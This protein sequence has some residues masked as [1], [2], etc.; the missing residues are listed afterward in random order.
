MKKLVLLINLTFCATVIIA[1]S[2]SNVTEANE[3]ETIDNSPVGSYYRKG[4][5]GVESI[6][7]L[8]KD[9]TW[10]KGLYQNGEK[11][12]WIFESDG[13]GT[14][15]TIEV[16]NNSIKD[17]KKYTVVV[18]N[19]DNYNSYIFDGGCFFTTNDEVVMNSGGFMSSER[20]V[21]GTLLY[22]NKVCKDNEVRPETE[23][24]PRKKTG[25]NSSVDVRAEKN[26]VGSTENI[27][28]DVQ[29][30]KDLYQISDPDGYSN[31]RSKPKG[32]IIRK[33][34]DNEYFT[35]GDTI[36]NHIEVFFSDGTKGFIHLSRIVKRE[37]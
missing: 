13:K 2:C 35:L 22:G 5:L 20:G 24:M 25:E 7:T 32:Q 16:S 31:L 18:F 28:V 10:L 33:V 15:K 29:A 6:V 17:E 26:K 4:S 34:Y 36:S 27:E 23:N 21:F 3:S 30:Y 37:K 9:G 8:N 14:W 12:E 19:D 1:T 11:H